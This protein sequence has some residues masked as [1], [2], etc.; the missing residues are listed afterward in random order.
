MAAGEEFDFDEPVAVGLADLPVVEFGQ[1][2]IF[3]GRAWAADVGFVL[4]FIAPHHV[5]ESAFCRVRSAADQS[6]IEF[7]YVG[8]A[9]HGVQTLKGLGCFGKDD[10]AAD[11]TVEAVRQ[12]HENLT[13][14]FVTLGDECFIGLGER[15]VGGLVALDDLSYLFVYN[16]EMVVFI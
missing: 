14:L 15:F 5:F 16:Q 3:A 9:E 11:R 12:A 13:W 2:G 1:F 8:V 10:D 4:L 7:M 6:P